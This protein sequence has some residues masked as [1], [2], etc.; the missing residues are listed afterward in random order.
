MKLTSIQHITN[1]HTSQSYL[2]NSLL[3]KHRGAPPVPTPT[4]IGVADSM[5]ML[6]AEKRREVKSLISKAESSKSLRLHWMRL[7]SIPRD[8]LDLVFITELALTGNKL[9]RLPNALHNLR[10]L[11]SINVS[12]NLIARIASR[13]LRNCKKLHTAQL[14]HNMLTEFPDAMPE[15]L[16]Y[17]D[18]SGNRIVG[19]PRGPVF[20]ALRYLHLNGN[21]TT[22]INVERFPL[23]C[24]LHANDN[25]I[26]QL[27]VTI[28]MLTALTSLRLN[29]NR[30]HTLPRSMGGMTNIVTLHLANNKFNSV[31]MPVI[32]MADPEYEDAGVSG[33]VGGRLIGRS[34]IITFERI[35]PLPCRSCHI[36]PMPRYTMLVVFWGVR[37]VQR[38]LCDALRHY[39]TPSIRKL[40]RQDNLAMLPSSSIILLRCSH[41]SLNLHGGGGGGAAG[42]SPQPSLALASIRLSK[43]SAARLGGDRHP[44]IS[45]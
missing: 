5:I 28:V 31:P 20:P 42:G 6:A 15:S 3:I 21:A 7:E 38:M 34:R 23:L 16:T 18:V 35:A 9:R 24:T 33:V 8:A 27:P 26:A 22:H 40:C 25:R 12:S 1:M 29:N 39:D 19:V 32:W 37:K 14:S 17:L 4:V 30:L 43:I 36:M 44:S 13:A 2:R 11:T 45:A 41:N 10:N